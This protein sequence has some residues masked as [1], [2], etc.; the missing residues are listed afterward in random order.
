MLNEDPHSPAVV[1]KIFNPGSDRPSKRCYLSAP[2]LKITRTYSLTSTLNKHSSM[3]VRIT[4]NVFTDMTTSTHVSPCH[5]DETVADEAVP[6][7]RG[8]Y[9][10]PRSWES[11]GP[12]PGDINDI[13]RRFSAQK[14][15]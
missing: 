5:V 11:E 14:G 3:G 7:R 4:N 15:T 13:T 12:G 1:A 2:G 8:Y 10:Q 6:W 9:D